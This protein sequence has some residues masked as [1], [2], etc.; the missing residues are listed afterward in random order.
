MAPNIWP[1]TKVKAQGRKLF[2][3]SLMILLC[4]GKKCVST[5]KRT[6]NSHQSCCIMGKRLKR[7]YRPLELVKL[8]VY[9][10]NYSKCYC[11]IS[12]LMFKRAPTRKFDP[13]WK[14]NC[15]W[16]GFLS[17]SNND[18]FK[19]NQS[20]RLHIHLH[21][22]CVELQ[23][24][25]VLCWDVNVVCQGFSRLQAAA[26]VFTAHLPNTF[27]RGVQTWQT[28]AVFLRCLEEYFNKY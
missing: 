6:R 11:Q 20:Q 27:K 15:A 9:C 24:L 26:D 17:R 16:L 13:V 3:L 2:V 22:S 12:L 8:E 25:S 5:V 18:A 19:I 4:Q 28:P 23:R 7:V 10:M 21:T 14:S 1:E